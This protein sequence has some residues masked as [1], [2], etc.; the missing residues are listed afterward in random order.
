MR[1]SPIAL[2]GGEI[3]ILDRIFDAVSA[4]CDGDP[5]MVDGSS[6]RVHRH[7][8]NGNPI[9]PE[10]TEGEAHVGRSAIDMPESVSRGRTRFTSW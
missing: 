6:S 5:Q 9:L 2:S 8:A 3:D 7:A 1:P 4:A 10:S